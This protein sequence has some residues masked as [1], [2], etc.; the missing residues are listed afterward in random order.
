MWALWE[1]VEQLSTTAANQA[2]YWVY[3]STSWSL[4][5]EQILD[6]TLWCIMTSLSAPTHIKKFRRPHTRYRKYHRTRMKRPPHIPRHTG[7]VQSPAC[8]YT[9][10][11]NTSPHANTSPFDTDSFEIGIDNHATSCMTNSLHDF[12]D[13]SLQQVNVRVKG[14]AGKLSAAHRGTLRWNITDDTGQP[15]QLLIPNA[16]YVPSLPIRLLSPQHF[17]Q[18][19][20]PHES[21]NHGTICETFADSVRLHWSDR[22]YT[23]TVPLGPN[24]VATLWTTSGHW[25]YTAYA[26]SVRPD[27]VEPCA[28]DAHWIPPDPDSVLHPSAPGSPHWPVD[29]V[30]TTFDDDV[31]LGG[32]VTPTQ[33]LLVWHFRL[34]HLSFKRLQHMAKLG[35][36]PKKLQNCRIPECPACCYAKATKVPWRS[37]GQPKLSQ[38]NSTISKPGACVSIDQLESRTPGLIAQMKGQPTKSRYH[39]ATIFVDHYSD[40]SFVFLQ[41]EQSSEETL[42]AKR[43]FEAYAAI[44]GVTIQHYHADNGRFADKMFVEDVEHTKGQSISYCGVNAHF[45][46][47]KAEKRIRD[48]QDAARTQLNHAKQRWPQAIDTSLWPYAIRTVN[49]VLNHTPRVGQDNTPLERFARTQKITR[50]RYFHPFGCPVYVLDERIANNKKIPKWED[51]ARV[52][53]YLG[54]SPR[55]ARSVSLVL[56][57]T[58]GLVSPQYHVKHD[59][60]FE[61][62]KRQTALLYLWQQK[63]HLTKPTYDD[64]KVSTQL[65]N[66]DYTNIPESPETPQAPAISGNITTQPEGEDTA[67]DDNQQTYDTADMNEAKA[68]DHDEE[69]VSN[70]TVDTEDKTPVIGQTRSGRQVRRSHRLHGYVYTAITSDYEEQEA[71]SVE[72]ITEAQDFNMLTAMKASSDPDTMYYHEAMR[73]P[74]AQEFKQAMVKE[75]NDH[76]NRKHW[77]VIRKE[78]VP[79]GEIILPS[80]WAMR[81]KRRIATREVYKWKS[82]LNLGGHKMIEGIHYD[83]TFAPALTWATIRLFVTLS[84]IFDWKSR[85]IDFVL[86]YPQAPIP[87]PTFMELPRGINFPNNIDRKTHCLQI[88]M[89]IYGGKDAGR[90]WYLHLKNGLIK[91]GFEVSQIDECVF[92][93][94]TSILLVYT[95]DCIIFDTES[96]KNIDKLIHELQQHFHIED[97]GDVQEYLGVQVKKEEDGSIHLNQP[98]LIADILKDLGLINEDGSTR[99]NTKCRSTPALSTAIIGPDPGGQPFDETWNYKRVIGKLNFLEKSTRVDISYAVHQCSRFMAN[100]TKKHAE[101][102]KRIGRYLLATKDKGTILRPNIN[103]QFECWVDADFTGNWDPNIAMENVD[104]ARSRYGFIIKYAGVPVYWASKLASMIALSTT[105]S[106]YYGLSQATRYVKGTIYLLEELKRKGH[107]VHTQPKVFCEIFEDN[108]AALEMARRPKI[109]PRTRHLNVMMH[110]FHQQ[111][112]DKTLIPLPVDTKDQ[113]ADILTKPVDESTMTRLRERIMGW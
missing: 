7:H 105:E 67:V 53:V 75:V 62:I 47:G 96:A 107:K 45:Q 35:L 94:K 10:A 51:K 89:N 17:A 73:E 36:L 84:L 50:L 109:R 9:S 103:K 72:L 37:K 70:G 102:V 74:D 18:S 48:L 34:A 6:V 61:T 108:E 13:T 27:P 79:E 24:N 71:Y 40:L 12:V 41:K 14:I 63:C 15:H 59:N 104:T 5:Y 56:S 64:S 60:L 3:W 43:T 38:Q 92:Y 26:A 30:P 85:Q 91:I 82:R 44:H 22:R 110:H 86:A 57:L 21:T 66:P 52:G 65:H 16:Y 97:E 68:N 81:R 113:E 77:K 58:T 93:R 106:E 31:R 101:A 11:L 100:P 42:K 8:A 46:N 54:P 4:L 111:V 55:H 83:H 39:F 69:Q 1:T 49:Q 20:Q 33:E 98:H 78:Q 95:D 88:L 25:A 99:A 29:T 90:T 32:D 80:V 112:L 23:K 76:T 87:R 2:T 28:Y 19:M